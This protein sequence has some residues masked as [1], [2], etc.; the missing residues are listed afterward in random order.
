[1]VD[2]E[3]REYLPYSRK[4][5]V[6]VVQLESKREPQVAICTHGCPRND[7]DR[8]LTADRIGYFDGWEI[9]VEPWKRERVAAGCGRWIRSE[10]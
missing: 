9:D 7:E 3:L 2:T 10:C 6:Q 1:M 4:S 8:R 5:S